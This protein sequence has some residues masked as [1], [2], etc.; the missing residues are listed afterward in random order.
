MAY[1]KIKI[2]GNCDLNYVWCKTGTISDEETTE[3]VSAGIQSPVWDTNTILLATFKGNLSGV[4]YDTSQQISKYIIQKHNTRNNVVKDVAVVDYA[5]NKI[6]DYNIGNNS[7]YIYTITPVYDDNGKEAMGL[8]IETNTT[9]VD[10]ED[11]YII[12]VNPTDVKNQ[13]VVDEDNLWR[14]GL[15]VE[16]SGLTSNQHKVFVD[17][18][19]Q[20]P[21]AYSGERNYLSGNLTCLIVMPNMLE[22]TLKS[23]RNGENS[24][25]MDS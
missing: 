21:K 6:Q 1:S 14:L 13:Y 25:I 10:F 5:Q 12:G 7:E 11:W 15:N 8:P 24:V 22:M 20:F 17:N 19:S 18:I 9:K 4:D 16:C 23:L 2:S 3:I